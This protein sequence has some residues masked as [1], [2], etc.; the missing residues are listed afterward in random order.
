MSAFCV[1]EVS[2]PVE[3]LETITDCLLFS[4]GSSNEVL[5]IDTPP[6]VS[7]KPVAMTPERREELNR[8]K[9]A[10]SILDRIEVMGFASLPKQEQEEEGPVL[11][12]VERLTKEIQAGRSA[13]ISQQRITS[14][15]TACKRRIKTLEALRE[16]FVGRYAATM[17]FRVPME[18]EEE[19]R[20]QLSQKVE[21]IVIRRL[22]L[23]KEAKRSSWI[24]GLLGRKP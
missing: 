12:Q 7:M 15:R 3:S 17:N 13:G 8:L 23:E 10:L 20:Q 16:A 14:F 5:P 11:E 22:A 9:R 24:G 2:V 21:P 19:I 6:T 18:E 1:I 4:L